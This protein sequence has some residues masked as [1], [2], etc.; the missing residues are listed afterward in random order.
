MNYKNAIAI[1]II[2]IVTII[3]PKDYK[4]QGKCS[5]ARPRSERSLPRLVLFSRAA[6]LTRV[7]RVHV[8]PLHPI[9]IIQ[10]WRSKQKRPNWPRTTLSTSEAHNISGVFLQ[11]PF[12]RRRTAKG[13]AR[14]RR[15]ETTD[16]DTHTRTRRQSDWQKIFE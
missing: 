9:S 7:F 10:A 6:E 14:A 12:R 4:F 1:P 5:R 16:R 13:S 15:L 11:P 2:I 8:N 3:R